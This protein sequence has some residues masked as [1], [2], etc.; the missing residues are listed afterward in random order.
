MKFF[1]DTADLDAIRE[2][3]EMGVLDGV[4]TNPTHVSKQSASF[5]DIILQIC[6]VV[7]G[8][9]SAEVVST[10][11]DGMMEE[12]RHLAALH[13]QVVVKVPITLEG[14]KAVKACTDEGIRT[15]VTLCFSPNQALLA[16]KAGAAYISPFVGRLDDIAHDGMEL[17]ETIRTIYDNYGYET[18]I[19]AASLRHPLHVIQ[20]ATAGADVATL[21]PDV[22]QKLLVHP[23]TESGL[24][25]FLKDWNDWQQQE[26]PVIA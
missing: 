21:P 6:G 4:T 26:A 15:N 24:E 5:D 2:A 14:L 1:I 23:L 22:L 18:Q 25:R 3:N 12:A 11:R 13:E 8:P 9:V 20:A 19:L 7:D 16:A 10:K 17:I